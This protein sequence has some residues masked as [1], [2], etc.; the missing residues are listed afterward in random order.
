MEMDPSTRS[1]LLKAIPKLR[2]FALSLCRNTERADDL[3]QETLMRACASIAQFRPGTSMTPWLTAILR[4]Q[5]YSEYRKRRREIGDPE[6]IHASMLVSPAAQLP[7]ISCGELGT[8]LTTLPAEMR[9]A[10]VMVGACGL[11]YEDAARACGCAIG[12]IKSRV[13]RGR[14]RLASMLHIDGTN[15]DSDPIT[16]SVVVRTRPN[17]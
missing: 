7:H 11:S 16:H 12:T 3:V 1:N 10:I 14:S 2:A 5:Y 17:P 6:G 4:N 9:Q 13:H 15:F 8:A